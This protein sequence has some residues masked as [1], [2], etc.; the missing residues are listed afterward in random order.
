MGNFTLE[1][2]NHNQIKKIVGIDFLKE[3]I[4][5]ARENKK[6]EKVTF[7]QGDLVNMPF[8]DRSFDVT[9]CLNVLHHIHKE[10]FNKTLDLSV[11]LDAGHHFP[12][13][14]PLLRN[15]Q[16][17]RGFSGLL[18]HTPDGVP[19]IDQAHPLES[20]Y[21]AAGFCGHGFCLGPVVGRLMAE[22]IVEG[23][24]SMDLH[25]FSGLRF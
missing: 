6:F 21:L 16:I 10:D 9:F 14:F 24:P 15:L 18:C 3:T 13:V 11:L 8:C 22:W 5:L 1:L 25:A 7:F 20:L 19:I 4:N 2:A 23:R 17:I 12:Q